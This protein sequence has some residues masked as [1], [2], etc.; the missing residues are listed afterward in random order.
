M[1]TIPN[2]TAVFTDGTGANVA[3]FAS[4]VYR[5]DATTPESFEVINGW[6]DED[7]LKSGF[8][9]RSDMVQRGEISRVVQVGSTMPLDY[10]RNQFNNRTYSRDGY[11]PSD[12]LTSFVPI[13]GAY[14]TQYV[15]GQPR[16]VLLTW[17]IWWEND[18]SD[19]LNGCPVRLAINGRPKTAGNFQRRV[20]PAA[21]Y[22]GG[23]NER[24]SKFANQWTGHAV[25]DATEDLVANSF[26]SFG[27]VIAVSA[28][29]RQVRVRT[30]A[31]RAI[32]L[33]DLG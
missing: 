14:M 7:N 4:S 26:N 27:L 11:S 18:L 29:A 5:P 23:A 17:N 31:F 22:A 24:Y 6:L 25:V 13:P 16:L 19:E 33:N 21:Y 20:A 2:M 12:D 9:V 3:D 8:L 28:P 30:R 1:P 10:F 32:M 15:V